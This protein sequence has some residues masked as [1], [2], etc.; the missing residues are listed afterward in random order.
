MCGVLGSD[1]AMHERSQGRGY[2][3]LHETERFPWPARPPYRRDIFA[4]EF[5]HSALTDPD[6]RWVYGYEVR[7][8]VGVDGKHDG[9]VHRN[10]L[11]SYSHLRDV[12]G[13]GWTER[14]ISRVR[15]LM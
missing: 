3:R 13:L 15:A 12:G 1:V 2:V 4:H 10:L 5:H 11:A 7:R 8:G 9:I 14:F 6:P